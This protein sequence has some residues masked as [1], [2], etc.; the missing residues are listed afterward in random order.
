MRR[1]SRISEKLKETLWVTIYYNLGRVSPGLTCLA[2]VLL[3]PPSINHESIFSLLQ[4]PLTTSWVAPGT[5]T[6]NW[7]GLHQDDQYSHRPALLAKRRHRDGV[8]E[9]KRNAGCFRDWYE[10]RQGQLNV[11]YNGRDSL[12]IS[13]EVY[14][15]LEQIESTGRERKG[16]LNPHLTISITCNKINSTALIKVLHIC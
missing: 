15:R 7:A 14:R 16:K 11:G 1:Q 12:K 8:P 2:P 10:Q 4:L 13:F 5:H 3:L 9:K 6:S